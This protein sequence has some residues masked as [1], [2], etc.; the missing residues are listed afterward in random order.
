MARAV[1]RNGFRQ[2]IMM[3]TNCPPNRRFQA[4]RCALLCAAPLLLATP[5]PSSGQVQG[6]PDGLIAPPPANGPVPT[7]SPS[8]TPAPSPPPSPAPVAPPVID[9]TNLPAATPLVRPAAPRSAPA[10]EAGPRERDVRGDVTA[11]TVDAAPISNAVPPVA[12]P[13]PTTEIVAPDG[14]A[15]TTESD[16]PLVPESGNAMPEWLPLAALGGVAMLGIGF[17]LWWRRKSRGDSAIAADD[18]VNPPVELD[19]ELAVKNIGGGGAGQIPDRSQDRSPLRTP[20]D[21]PAQAAPARAITGRRA[22]IIVAFEPLT[23]QATLINFRMRYAITLTNAGQAKATPILVRVGMFAGTNAN[24]QGVSTWYGQPIEPDHLRIESIGAGEMHRFESEM[25][26]PL[27]AL[28]PLVIEGR[29]MAIPLIAID[30]RYFHGEGEA[31]LDGQT[32]RAFVVGR[33]SGVAG[34][35][36]APF[37]LDQGSMS[38]APL[39][40]RDTGISKTE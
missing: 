12:A 37:R 4:L 18:A 7:P 23:A 2:T 19:G 13:A 3:P 24:P 36:L 14:P 35:K 6:P 21:V 39:G 30:A 31:P 38:F 1:R 26:V 17:A 11:P 29:A 33:D 15:P 10:R 32:A 22:D 16:A 25:A 27:D 28:N 5:M 40:Q 9:A 34:A 8:P 20:A